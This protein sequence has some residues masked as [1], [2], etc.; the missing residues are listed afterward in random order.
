[1]ATLYV[2]NVPEKLYKRIRKLVKE[3]GLSISAKVIQFLSQGLRM[4]ESRRNTVAVIARIRE[5]AQEIELPHGWKDS[6]A[7]IREGRSR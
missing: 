7:L 6:V 5:R 3:E 2:R 4:R 1:M